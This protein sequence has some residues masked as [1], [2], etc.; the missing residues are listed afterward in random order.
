MSVIVYSTPT[1]GFC[2]QVKSYLHQRGTRFTEFDVSS[3]QAAAREMIQLSGQQ[4]VPVVVIDGQVVIGFN[5]P[6]IDQLLAA[7]ES[8]PARLGAAIADAQRIASG[9]GLVLP[10]GA[11]IGRVEVD[12]A[13]LRAGLHVGDVIVELDGQPVRTDR[14]VDR[15]MA[16]FRPRQNARMRVWRDGKTLELTLNFL[17]R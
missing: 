3:D 13:G 14:D 15:I 16:T 17:I 10:A 7:S 1:C 9:K 5:R 8:R 12:G 4:G 6:R 11:Y 2:R